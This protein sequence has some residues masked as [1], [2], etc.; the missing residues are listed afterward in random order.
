VTTE[1]MPAIRRERFLAE[2]DAECL[3][4]QG[5]FS[6]QNLTTPEDIAEMKVQ[7]EE[8]FRKRSGEKE[9]AYTDLIESVDNTDSI[10]SPQIL[11]P[12]N[13]APSLRKTKCFQNG[14]RIAKQLLGDDAFCLFDLAIMKKAKVGFAT[15]WHQDEAFR[16]PRFDYRELSIW[17]PLQ[18]VSLENGCMQFIPGSHKIEI[19]KHD[20]PNHNLAATALECV[21]SFDKSQAVSCPLP[22]GGATVHFPRT[23]H[24]TGP[25]L[26]NAP[27]IAYI[28]VFNLP[29]KSAA[30]TRTFSWRD[31][32]QTVAHA[33]RRSWMRR[34]GFF[35]TLWRRLRRGEVGKHLTARYLLQRSS[36]ILRK[37]N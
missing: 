11:N 23:L 32:Q 16:D 6:V 5:F 20:S 35:I 33:R 22:V 24:G 14:L 15:P 31:P 9:G 13:Y 18:G 10:T 34:G 26:S 19:L 30:K 36:S 37:G 29:P 17:V 28:M 12:V 2:Q 27:R 21:D 7:L 4:E 1:A 3:R 25:N 8:L